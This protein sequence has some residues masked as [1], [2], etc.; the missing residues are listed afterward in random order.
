MAVYDGAYA[1]EAL[2]ETLKTRDKRLI[3]Y[4]VDYGMRVISAFGTGE[5]QV[6]EI[7]VRDGRILLRCASHERR[8]RIQSAIS[9][10]LLRR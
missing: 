7:H 1:D 6:R 2:F 10:T 5:Q 9:T 4:A 3:G 8:T